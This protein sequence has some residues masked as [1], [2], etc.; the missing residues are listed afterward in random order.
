[1]FLTPALRRGRWS[2]AGRLSTALAASASMLLASEVGSQSRLTGPPLALIGG[3]L[4]DGRGGKP[5]RNS[6]VLIRTRRIDAT[7][8]VDGTRVPSGYLRIS[9]E[10]RYVLPGLWDMHTHL[11]YSAH[12]DLT[13]WNKRYLQR[14]ES[15]IMPA[16]AE[17]LLMA[18]VTS[19]RDLMAPLDPILRVRDRIAKD[20][21]PGPTLYVAGALLE[22]DPPPGF[23]SF[24]WGVSGVSDARTKVD[25]LA[26]TGVNIIKLLCVER[27]TVAEATAVVEQAHA[28]GLMV[29]AHG[30]DDAEIRT[31]LDAGVDDFQH[32]GT[33][34]VL[35]D[36]I[37]EGIR[38]RVSV[39]P[40]YWTPTVGNLINNFYLKDDAEM[41][42]DSDWQRGLPDDIV[43]DVRTSLKRL[44][45]MLDRETMSADQLADYRRKFR[46]L[47][48][49]GAQLL[50][51]T[52]SGAPGNFHPYATWLE[53][54]AWVNQF[55][56]NPMDA[57]R[58]ATSIPAAVMGV[59]RDYG[60]I[61]TGKYADIIVAAGDPLR[62]ID[63]LR[64]PVVI[65]KHGRRVK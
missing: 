52:D 17:Q 61:E 36:D 42:D 21:I 48:D 44:P 16:I 49:A 35:P 43:E 3:T 53:L 12:T 22:H 23:E 34:G 24:R 4:I 13:A 45:T 25:R 2:G 55:G 39:R 32:L 58:R 47:Q 57:I 38:Q 26:D 50:V 15:A 19:A 59:E 10:G 33:R 8:T 46:Q 18:G 54:D 6:V 31:C 29:A 28:R 65:I 62:H 51:G 27:M 41:L 5:I 63:V 1:M 37:V 9:T 56:V 11:Q 40:L 14:M 60:T 7:G 64:N 20:Q 30:R